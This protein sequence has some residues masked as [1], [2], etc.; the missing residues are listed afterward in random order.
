M[1][2]GID[3]TSHA[4]HWRLLPLDLEEDPPLPRVLY[5]LTE[6][7][8]LALIITKTK[9]KTKMMIVSFIFLSGAF[10]LSGAG[11]VYEFWLTFLLC[12]SKV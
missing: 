1:S 3:W 6:E 2:V 8:R 4:L 10:S 9:T 7:E 5:A 11:G 12:Y